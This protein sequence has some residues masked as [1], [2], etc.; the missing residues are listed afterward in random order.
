MTGS[1]ADRR[2][3][4]Y[5]WGALAGLALTLGACNAT[6]G[7]VVATIPD[8][9]KMR[10]PIAIEEGRHAIAVFVG[11]GR[12]GLTL[13]QRDDIIGLAR[14]WQ[15]E[16]TGAIVAEVPAGTPNARAAADTYRE[17]HALLTAGGVPSRVITMR[18]TTPDDPRQ[19]AVIRLSYPKIAAVAGPCGLWPDDLGPNI[20]NP[21]YSSNQH[22]QNFGCATQRNLA[23]MIDNPADLEQPRSE[24]AA[25][26]PRRSA[27]FEKYRK[28]EATAVTYPEAEK[29]KLSD[30]GK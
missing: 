6:S 17:I 15:R 19:F 26:T 18:H 1:S 28:G 27:L 7:E 16:G 24:T 22:Y 4:L 29:A 30:T 9:Y 5:R 11:N 8:D 3:A 23:A 21:G 13:P 25:Y 20:N 14:S 10:H 12:G 2:R